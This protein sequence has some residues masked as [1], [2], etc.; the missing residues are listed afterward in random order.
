MAPREHQT[1]R[2]RWWLWGFLIVAAVIASIAAYQV[3]SGGRPGRAAR[4][5]ARAEE[6]RTHG[7]LLRARVELRNAAVILPTDG[8]IRYLLG[9]V[10]EESSNFSEALV[11]YEAAV[12]ANPRDAEARSAQARLL[13]FGGHLDEALASIGKGISLDADN[14]HLLALRG[15]IQIRRGDLQAASVDINAAAQRAPTDTYVAS[16]LASLRQ[17]QGDSAGAMRAIGDA[18]LAHPDSADLRAIM[19]DLLE[20][21]ERRDDALVQVREMVRIQPKSMPFRLRLARLLLLMDRP[22]DAEQALRDAVKEL[23]GDEAREE[24]IRFML[25]RQGTAAALREARTL[26]AANR[27]EPAVQVSLGRFL[28]D[29]GLAEDAERIFVAVL[30]RFP[31]RVAVVPAQTA[32]AGLRLSE[33][34]TA[35]AQ[36]LVD[37]VLDRDPRNNEALMVRSRLALGRGDPQGAIADLRTVLRATPESVPALRELVQAYGATGDPALAEE[38]VRRALDTTPDDVSLRLTLAQLLLSGHRDAEALTL[39]HKLAADTPKSFEAQE[40]IFRAAMNLQRADEARVAAMT[41]QQLAPSK[42]TGYYRLATLEQA[43]GRWAEAESALQQALARSDG[44]GEPLAAMIR[45]LAQHGQANR[46]LALVDAAILR[47][48]T[49]AELNVFRGDILTANPGLGDPMI[50]YQRAIDK[51][52]SWATGYRALAGAQMARK[53]P[54]AALATLTAGAAKL[55]SEDRESVLSDLA[56][57]NESLGKHDDAISAYE[58]ALKIAPNNPVYQNNLALLLITYRTDAESLRKADSLAE[59]LTGLNSPAF[60]DTRGWVKYKTGS[61]AAAAAILQQAVDA[62]PEEP[63]IRYHLAVVQNSLSDHTGARENLTKA[64]SI[65]RPFAER[66]AAEAL[67]QQVK[68]FRRAR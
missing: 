34:K 37:S 59:R 64:L 53:D 3:L 29:N 35:E 4:H 22:S 40:G 52:P 57:L 25:Q 28:L 32:L 27:D 14:P 65:T 11:H 8:H 2:T 5:V 23:S 38:S 33:G 13:V 66:P 58:Q 16:M 17:Q 48:P 15:E 9:R 47:T 46:A 44:R 24:L 62:L 68:T 51:A 7:D 12:G 55:K 60:L 63:S 41:E 49:D 45:L 19:A 30:S 1:R 56:G 67:L 43:L 6:Y 18:L 54:K 39:L 21:S 42:P 10:E 31:D 36:K 61:S 50:E 20:F 26:I